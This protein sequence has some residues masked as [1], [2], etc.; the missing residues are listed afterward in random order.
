LDKIA[1]CGW[2]L[3]FFHGEKK[4]IIMSFRMSVVLG[5][6]HMADQVIFRFQI[7]AVTDKASVLMFWG[8]ERY[9]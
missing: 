3:S 9:T 1:F 5:V 8:F 7:T 6:C 2:L 4:L